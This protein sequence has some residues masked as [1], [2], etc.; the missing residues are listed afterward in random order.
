MKETLLA[1]T[2]DAATLGGN[3]DGTAPGVA[4][5]TD[6]QENE[7]VLADL[8]FIQRIYVTNEIERQ[9]LSRISSKGVQAT[10][11]A[12]YFVENSKKKN[13]STTK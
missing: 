4:L 6:E 3:D 11:L 5:T 9:I 1:K 13:A 12:K 10:Q 8:E 7:D 2:E